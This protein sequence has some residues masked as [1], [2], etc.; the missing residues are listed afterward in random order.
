M[1]FDFFPSRTLTLYLAKMFSLRILAVLVMLVLVLMMLDLLSTSGEILAVEGNSEADLWR[2]AS[3]RVPLLIQRFLPY[4][5]LLATIITL[6]TL[7]QNSEVIAM[8]ASGLS[9]HQVLA[10]LIMTALVVSIATFAFNERVVTRA[11]SELNVWEASEFGALSQA[12][13]TRGS[14]YLVDGSDILTARGYEANGPAPRLT[15]VTFYRRSPSGEIVQ[16]ID[17]PLAV[18][19]NDGWAMQTPQVF[20][21]GT[22]ST[23][24]PDEL[25]VAPG[26]TP[27][28]IELASVDPAAQPFWQLDGSIDAYRAA[29]RDTGEL[30]ANYWHKISGPLSAML[31]PILGA[32]AGFGLARSG[33]LF[34][35]AVTGMF[36]GFAYFVIDNAA[37]AMGDFGGYPPFLA[38]WAPFFLFLL[39]GE[40]VLV[41]TE[42]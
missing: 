32:V 16:Q 21:V 26:I 12:E 25:I 30:E 27:A 6:V 20:T 17:A 4:S 9:A 22:A 15:D 14:I 2:Y 41:R 42:E 33:Q 1:S 29:G 5:V 40:T 37:L 18:R 10:P 7:N 35:R 38:A 28:Q 24:L 13:E 8:K 31:M 11:A 3:L 19:G 34:V 23:T 36:L 39:I